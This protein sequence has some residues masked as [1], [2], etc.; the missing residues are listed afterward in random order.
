VP[1]RVTSHLIG[2]DDL[3]ADLAAVLHRV[4][5]RTVPAPWPILEHALAEGLSPIYLRDVGMASGMAMA[6]SMVR[7]SGRTGI[8]IDLA[9]LV[10]AARPADLIG[11]AV[12]ESRL[13]AGVIIAGPIELVVERFP[14]G[15]PLMT[16]SGCPL[17]LA[18]E[19]SW[20]PE[21]SGAVPLVLEVPHPSPEAQ[22]AGWTAALDGDH[23]PGNGLAAI[24]PDFLRATRA[25]RLTPSQIARAARAGSLAAQA[26]G[27][28]IQ[29]QDLQAGARRQNAAGLERLARRVEPKAGWMDLVLPH[30]SRIQL[31]ELAAR[32]R[33]RDRVLDEWRIGGGA[34]R[35]RGITA[36]FAGESGT[37]KT[38]TAEVIAAELGL[39]LYVID[40]ATVVDKYIGETEKNLDRIFAEADRVNGVLLFDEADAI[41]G[42]RS[43]VRDARD[44]YANVEVAYLLQRM[45]RFNGL[46]I[47]TTNLRA[48]LDEAFTRRIDAIVDFPMPE[49]QDRLAIWRMH[50]PP[51]LPQADDVDLEFLARRFRFSGGNIRNVC[52]M[53]AFLAADADQPVAMRDL[54]RGTEQEYRKLGRLTVEDEFGPYFAQMTAERAAT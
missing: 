9:R 11:A 13:R 27:R 8:A 5:E 31:G 30:D 32:A 10:A 17:V 48:N 21:W 22:L 52:L 14:D 51:R 53:A 20:D 41:F 18:G 12:R 26:E 7:A 46:A 44:R 49:D 39:D 15:L 54:I 35:G 50:L 23:V 3:E 37:G 43:E 6:T 38:L 34:G 4:P 45:E 36:L 19:R 40:L 28:T 33:Q 24:A 47:L 42:K 16:E 1:D 25:F 29:P 2:S